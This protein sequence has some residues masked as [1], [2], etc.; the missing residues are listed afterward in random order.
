MQAKQELV[1]EMSRPEVTQAIATFDARLGKPGAFESEVIRRGQYY[2]QVHKVSPPASQLVQEVL[3]FVGSKPQAPQTTA[4]QVVHAQAE[5][6]VIPTFAGGSQK[7]PTQ[8]MPSSIDDLK[9]LRQQ[10]QT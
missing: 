9:R 7:S 3:A 6:P 1:S 2:E 4:S 10:R 5:K 8:K